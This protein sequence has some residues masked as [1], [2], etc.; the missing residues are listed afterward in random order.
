MRIPEVK[1]DEIRNSVNILDIVNNHVALKKRGKNFIGL[2]PF[3]Q[4]KTPSFTVS[5][6]KQIFHCFGCGAGGDVF[7]FLMSY[8]NISFIEAVQEIAEYAG[9]KL[10]FAN[11]SVSSEQT[12]QELLYE[13]NVFAAKYFSNN[14]L[15]SED[16]EIARQYFKKRNIKTGTQ[17]VFGLGYA[18]PDWQDL[19]SLLKENNFDLKKA[20]SLGLIDKKN[21]GSYYDKFRGRVIFPIFSVNGRVIAFGGR[22]FEA[23]KNTAKYLNSQESLIYSKRKSLYGLYHSKDEIRKND[24]AILVE[25]YMDLIS[26]YQS[27]IKNVV[28]S[29]GTS[30]TD[31]QVQ[32]LSRFTHNIIVL[33]DADSAGQ[34]AA[35]RSIEILLKQNF[36]VK[37]I[38][39]PEGEDPDSFIHKYGKDDFDK[40]VSQAK[41]FLEFQTEQFE[42]AG[43]LKDAEE[44]VKSIR[45]LV[46]TIALVDDELKRSIFIK[47]ISKKFNLREKLI[48]SELERYVKELQAKEIRQI[49]L[50]ENIVSEKNIIS[51]TTNSEYS[52][53][54]SSFEKEL[55]TLM[56]EGNKDILGIIFD[57]IETDEFENPNVKK[58]AELVFKNFRSGI[59]SPASLIEQIENEEI[60]DFVIKLSLNQEA[61]SK[62]WEEMNNG[63]KIELDYKT[64]AEDLVRSYRIAKIDSEIEKLNR[65]L[66]KISDDDEVLKTMKLINELQREKKLIGSGNGNSNF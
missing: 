44:Q 62:R 60:K 1:I 3:H 40:L 52:K 46:K 12:E 51:A 13:I 63:E 37:V 59:Y 15:N 24:R 58:L 16:G 25:G 55:I 18:K 56:F 35:L 6:D 26:L 10:S 47:S 30:L 22:V 38:S 11:E 4:E 41:N 20:E 39:L 28:A 66:S 33:F 65:E 8:K 45:E 31:E 61:I 54:L 49:N 43:R 23:D 57:H 14:L 19:V 27:G 2:C 64:Y 42:K 36:E 32:L 9:I 7:K 17:K 50:K 5:E 21:D 48:E 53:K 29:S 34:K